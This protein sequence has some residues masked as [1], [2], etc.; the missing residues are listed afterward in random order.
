MID[1]HSHILPGLDDGAPDLEESLA[2]LR[3]AA[4]S[5][6]T[7]IVASPHANLEFNFDPAG[8]E[9]KI[10][11]LAGAFEGA[12]RIHYGCD[13]HLHYD[14]VL[15]ALANPTKYNIAH[16]NCLLVEIPELLIVKVAGEVL[17]RMCGAGLVPIIT[18]P[19]RHGTL[20][21]RF[22][23]MEAWTRLGCRVQVTGQSLTGGFG[24]HARA[25]CAELMAR[26]LVHFVASDAHDRKHRPPR[27]D[28]AREQ[29]REEYGEAAA[30]QLFVTNPA[31]VLAGEAIP[32]EVGVSRKPPRKWWRP[33][34]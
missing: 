4:E 19:E 9:A 13:F 3:L 23:L 31:A 34:N 26:G 27:L 16:K 29:V 17:E 20:Q 30:E 22:D 21:R 11:E 14:N 33:G 7:D 18:H 2:M 10:A 6:T 24:K 28:Q 32:A 12:I 8:V 25:S 5:G 15:D 1:I